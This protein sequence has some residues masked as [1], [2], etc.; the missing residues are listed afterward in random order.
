MQKK[1]MPK[2]I[3]YLITG[4]LLYTFALYKTTN[5]SIN[6][7]IDGFE[8]PPIQY[9]IALAMV[10]IIFIS[11]VITIYFNKHKLTTF[12]LSRAIGF[13][14]IQIP[15]LS[16]LS[17]TLIE[18]V[19]D[20]GSVNSTEWFIWIKAMIPP[21]M[22]MTTMLGSMRKNWLA[23]ASDENLAKRMDTMANTSMRL[24]S[25]GLL[26]YFVGG[27]SVPY[28]GDI[29]GMWIALLVIH[30][31]STIAIYLRNGFKMIK[32]DYRN[33]FFSWVDPSLPH[34]TMFTIIWWVISG[35]TAPFLADAVGTINQII[36]VNSIGLGL[37]IV[38]ILIHIFFK[39]SLFKFLVQDNPLYNFYNKALDN[40][41]LKLKDLNPWKVIKNYFKYRRKNIDNR[42]ADK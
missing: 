32:R 1:G 27:L 3:A 20:L 14:L 18:S 2:S 6:I 13:W 19:F 10:G 11:G 5:P 34:A 26:L 41:D 35:L 38:L 21:T 28:Y 16:L 29:K 36:I 9:W 8:M 22:L 12:Y 7:I 37:E 40:D 17:F 31:L 39:F 30:W 4:I 33:L 25:M 24:M 23:D 15:L 42:K